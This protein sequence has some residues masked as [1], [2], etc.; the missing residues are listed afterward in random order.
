VNSAK[1]KSF[2]RIHFVVSNGRVGAARSPKKSVGVPRPDLT[3]EQHLALQMLAAAPYGCTYSA[4]RARGVSRTDMDG[5][6]AADYV[7]AK[8]RSMR[9]GG[10]TFR[11][12][13]FLITSVGRGAIG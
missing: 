11:V 6:V 13:Q 1:R 12:T 2:A 5:L 3:V 8:P 9:A 4:L 10:R 7:V